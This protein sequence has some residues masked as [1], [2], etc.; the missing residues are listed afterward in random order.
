LLQAAT[1]EASMI[2]G[3]ARIYAQSLCFLCVLLPAVVA[4][5]ADGQDQKSPTIS[6]WRG[7]SPGDY[8]V[9]RRAYHG[10]PSLK[11]RVEYRKTVLLGAT[12]EGAPSFFS[13]TSDKPG[14]PWT[15]QPGGSLITDAG[16]DTQREAQELAPAEIRVGDHVFRCRVV[17]TIITDDWGKKTRTQW[18]DKESGLDV[19]C[20]ES[21]EGQDRNGRASRWTLTLVTTGIETVTIGTEKLTCLV[22]DKEQILES[23]KWRWHGLVSERVPG[24][25]V[26]ARCGAKL[27]EAPEFES[28]LI[29]WGHD[30]SLLAEYK[31]LMPKLGIADNEESERKRQEEREKM[32]QKVAEQHRRLLADLKSPDAPTRQ[33]AVNSLSVWPTAGEIDPADIEG[34]KNALDD[35][36]PEVRRRA[37]W[38]IGQ[39]GVK[40][41]AKK[42]LELLQRD[43]E[44]AGDYI[45]GLGLQGDP[46]AVPTLTQFASSSHHQRKALAALE[47]FRTDEARRAL[48]RALHDPDNSVRLKAVQSLEKAGDASSV[49]ALLG[50]L[51]D[52]YQLVADAALRAIPKIGDDSAVPALLGLLNTL[53]EKA[54]TELCANLGRMRLKNPEPVGDALLK[55]LDD[56]SAQVRIGVIVGLGELNEKRAVPKLIEMVRNAT[57]PGGNRATGANWAM[58]ALGKIGGPEATSVLSEMLDVPQLHSWA[59]NGFKAMGAPAMKPL[60][61]HLNRARFPESRREELHVLD[62]IGTK[63]TIAELRQYLPICPPPDKATVRLTIRRIEERLTR[64]GATRPATSRDSAATRSRP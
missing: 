59:C 31:S 8:V 20:E 19:R 27:E 15:A 16:P 39:L 21:Y 33:S 45:M 63:E 54:R 30:P 51:H 22:Q 57:K 11:D 49:P 52:P 18:I 25:T 32:R 34:V 9:E 36:A 37:A 44:G 5:H 14:G 53:D 12:K 40:G 42:I 1:K 43:P 4:S 24:L 23:G 2:N 55:M 3:S 46:E 38:G 6:E 48:E 28:S 26:T 58:V 60:L 61:A 29:A 50:I 17:R 62:Q 13:Y 41:M 7:F 56:P 47:N 64:E 35:P 10:L